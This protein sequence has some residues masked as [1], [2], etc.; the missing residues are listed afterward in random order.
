ML[1][2]SRVGTTTDRGERSGPAILTNY[3]GTMPTFGST[4]ALVTGGTGFIG[5]HLTRRLLAE[6]ADVHAVTS[7]ASSTYPWRLLDVRERI[8]LHEVD[9]TDAA[10]VTALAAEVRP[11]HVFHLA[12]DTHV[13]RSWQRVDEC[14]RTN[15]Q[16]TVTLLRAIADHGCDRFVHVSTGDVYGRVA[17]PFREDARVNPMSPY[18]VSKY[19]AECYCLMFQRSEGWPVVVLRPFN[20]YGPAQSPDRVIPELIVRAL[21]GEDVELT[22]GLQTREFNYVE[23]LVDGMV[24]AACAPGIE[25]EVFNLGCGEERAIRDVV[26]VTLQL[27]GNPVEARFGALPE[28]PGEIGRVLSD[29][30]RAR[31]RL[32]WAPRVSLRDGLKRTVDWYRDRQAAHG[33]PFAP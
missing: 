24:R 3:P 21:R 15:V 8:S 33:P 5:S 32:Q 18:A 17:V 27:L 6:G 31:E 14:L 30:S 9:L 22:R 12:A 29:S 23:D 28:R 4:R 10:A 13:G 20:A 25:G 2:R 1:L 11:G 19:A 7:R 26:G 16:G